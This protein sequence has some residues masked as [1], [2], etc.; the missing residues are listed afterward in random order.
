MYDRGIVNALCRGNILVLM[1][2]LGFLYVEKII[3]AAW[4]RYLTSSCPEDTRLEQKN[5]F[6]QFNNI[7]NIDIS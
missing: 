5:D 6:I 2:L 3:M 1:G 7:Y 4:L